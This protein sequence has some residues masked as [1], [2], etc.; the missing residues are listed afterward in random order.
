V[1]G[2]NWGVGDV[3]KPHCQKKG[4]G[5][6]KAA[7]KKTPL[8]ERNKNLSEFRKRKAGGGTARFI[9]VPPRKGQGN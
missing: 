5:H 1:A 7:V 3:E 2:H 8:E 4:P 6:S 9:G